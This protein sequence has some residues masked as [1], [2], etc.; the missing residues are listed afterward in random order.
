LQ[1]IQEVCMS[2]YLP[3]VIVGLLAAGLLLWR[4]L[5][6]RR[7]NL[8]QKLTLEQLGFQPCPDRKTWLE[9][10][11][12]RIENN[13]EL[14]YEVRQP[15]RLPGEPT[16]YHYIKMRHRYA[17]EPAVAEEEIL[18]PIKRESAAGLVLTVKPSSLS[19]GLATRMMGAIATGPW[20]AQP[21]D[22]QRIEIPPDLKDTNLVGALGPRGASLYDIVDTSMLSVVQGLGDA[23][24][25]LVR[26][27]D[28][29]CSVAGASAQ[30][31]FRVDEL[32][33][34]VRPLL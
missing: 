14:S 15:K 32:L 33:A 7:A 24:G 28:S 16:V 13:R 26:F 2:E 20:D 11:I 19:P 1:N 10:T 3:F 12:A 8:S 5:S 6:S 27:R 29:W 23:G 21:D 22:L 30:I 17:D 25:M 9:E 31:P 18:F 4:V 34:R